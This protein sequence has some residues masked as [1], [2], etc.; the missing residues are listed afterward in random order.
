MKIFKPVSLFFRS[1]LLQGFWNYAQMQNIGVLF[2]LLPA[3]KR[4]YKNDKEGFRNALARNM[5]AFNSQPVMSA[6]SIGAM[7][8]QEQK[9][10]AAPPPARPEEEREYRIIRVST[11]NTAASI[12]DR[13]FWGTLKPLSLTLCLV[14]LF[15]EEV[16]VLYEG[17]PAEAVAFAAAL[18][19]AGSLLI[20]NVPALA[21]RFKGLIDSYGGNEENFYG[22]IK[23]N[24]NKALYFLK[25][26]G[27]IFT[28]FIILYGL[29]IKFR[30]AP[31]DIGSATKLSLLVSFLVLG[32]I[33]KKFNV[34][35]V[36]LYLAATAVFVAASVLA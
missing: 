5:E 30:G 2:I 3:L 24:W 10:A 9:I 19:L 33:M 6:Y 17:A 16:Q 13:L 8:Q 14:V 35:A 22:L 21:A 7:L 31:A 4:I 28:V 15:G 12:G 29:Y 32:I 23:I 1:F 27:Q 11:A 36:V 26:L 25:T 20:Y 18:A 34:P